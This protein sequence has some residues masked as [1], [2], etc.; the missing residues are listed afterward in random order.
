MPP[1]SQY[2]DVLGPVA[3]TPV[4]IPHD[5]VDGFLCAWW[6]RPAAYLD[7]RVRAAMSSFAR[8]G[9]VTPAL[10]QLAADLESGAWAAR[11]ADLLNRDSLDLGYR[12]V[13]TL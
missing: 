9:D 7:P 10:A 2:A 3:I 12:L 8:I 1:L 13:T 5:C 11:H 4:A 6:R